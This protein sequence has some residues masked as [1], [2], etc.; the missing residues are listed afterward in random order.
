MKKT[1]ITVW[2]LGFLGTG[3]C[4]GQESR[5]SIIGIVTDPSGAVIPG[6]EIKATNRATGTVGSATTNESGNYEIPYLLPG[7]YKIEV[8]SPGFKTSVRDRIDL[9][10]ADRIEIDFA[11][12][13]GEVTESVLVT[14][15]TP[16][17]E[18]TSASVGMVM[19]EQQVQELPVVGGNPFY[20]AGVARGVISPG[21]RSA[22]NPMDQGAATDNIVNGTRNMSE[23]SVDGAPNVV[24]RAAV[25]SP[26]QDLVQEFKIHTATFDASIG[27]AAGG[28][29]NVSIKSGT[30]EPHGTGYYNESRWRA[31][32]WFTNRFIYDPK[33]GPIT[34]EKKER[35]LEGW[36]HRRGGGTLTAPVY[37]PKLY[38]GRNKTFVSFGYEKLYILR[39][40]SGTYTVPSLAMKGGDLSE[41]L[42]AGSKYQIYDPLTTVPS[43][44]KGRFERKPLPGN[45]IPASR[46]DPIALNILDYYPAPNQQGTVDGRQNF[47]RTRNIDRWNR[48]IVA[49]VDHNI[50]DRHRVFFRANNSQHDNQDDTL[51][52]EATVTI[53]DR[54][55][56]GFVFDDVYTISPQTIMNFRYGITYQ[57]PDTYRGTQGFDLTTLGFPRSLVDDIAA[58]TDPAGFA[59][60][61]IYI[62][63]GAYTQL[64]DNGGNNRT[65]YYHNLAGTLTKIVN[66]HSLKAGIDFR[67]MRENGFAYGN[68]APRFN[69]TQSYTRGPLDNSP[70]APIGQG[71]AS[72][73]LGIPT[74]GNVSVNASRAEQSTF[75][76]LFIQ[77][78]W[79]ISRKLT[80]NFGLRWEYEGP[81]T[82]RF[83]R[84]V[85]G[86][87]FE[88]ESPIAAQAKANYALNPIPELPVSQFDLRGGLLF[89]GVG[90]Q[91]RGVWNGD[92]NNLAPRIGLAYKLTDKTILR[93]GYGIFYDVVGIDRQDVNQGGFN[94]STNIIASL[95]NGQ[96]Y[97][98]SIAAPFPNG[99]EA[100]SLSSTKGCSTRTCNAGRSHCSGNCPGESCLNPPIS[101]TGARSSTST[102]STTRR[103]RSICQ[104]RPSGTR[105]PS[106]S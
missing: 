70:T 77:D 67:L 9:R 44:K 63:G 8:E 71:L 99:I 95:D 100:A 62:D 49:R 29:T 60:P 96:T 94:Q 55:G 104:R 50:S 45:I 43:S 88:A 64:S 74:G 103:R 101:A 58:K 38:D 52:T 75:W 18:T 33:T 35:A 79:R 91:P 53:L 24:E 34:E 80:M 15:E 83:N 84:T 7:T 73:L 40:L 81:T 27:H 90:G 6:A 85:R 26:P 25:F 59:F 102:A 93:A 78:D 47:Y 14:G 2:L 32:P 87:D 3:V 69:F 12:E 68:V 89:A 17:L 65:M 37:I 20:L 98:A 10:V 23:A 1:L 54:T 36:R 105:R 16:L 82:E 41:L 30:N 11:L 92:R 48:T 4:L 19:Y 42:A 31:V 86:F 72:M 76:G 56:W 22:G 5:G 57:N 51:P 21:G 39:N 61:M 97:Q 46:L 28:M 13:V 66:T 106:T